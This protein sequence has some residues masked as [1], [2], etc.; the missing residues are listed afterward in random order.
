MNENT[1]DKISQKYN[2]E[3]SEDDLTKEEKT[4]L[5]TL[6]D[7]QYD[8]VVESLRWKVV[9]STVCKEFEEYKAG[10]LR[11][12][13]KSLTFLITKEIVPE[14]T[15]QVAKQWLDLLIDDIEKKYNKN[16]GLQRLSRC[17]YQCLMYLRPS[18]CDRDYGETTLALH[19]NVTACQIDKQFEELDF[20][21]IYLN[22]SLR[23]INFFITNDKV[24]N[25]VQAKAKRLREKCVNAIP[26]HIDNKYNLDS[27]IDELTKVEVY[28]L[29]G[30][31]VVRNT[32]SPV[33]K[34]LHWKATQSI[35]YE[36]FEDFQAGRINI[37]KR[38]NRKLDFL[39]MNDKV[40]DTIKATA[41]TFL[42]EISKR[43]SGSEQQSWTRNQSANI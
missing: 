30:L 22:T 26:E 16:T 14:T 40:P 17:E 5:L 10:N 39:S 19:W 13:S 36:E 2:L 20:D 8:P 4:I 41:K 24:P 12:M 6:K 28:S 1:V 11:E 7:K 3:S 21:R 25:F 23:R 42:E 43:N 27:N 33:V 35:L 9:H 15:R 37:G 34:R 32:Y 18:L 31:D 29:E 38:I